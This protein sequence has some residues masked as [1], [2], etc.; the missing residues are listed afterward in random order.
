MNPKVSIVI[1]CFNHG[2]FLPEAIAS[3]RATKREDV[4]I[5]VVDDGSTDVRTRE[6]TNALASQGITLIRKKNGGP[7][8]A[9][10]AGISLARGEYIFPLDGDDR[11]RPDCLHREIPILD[12]NPGV[13]VVY[14]DGEFFGI[15]SGRWGIGPFDAGRLLQWNYIP[16]CALFRRSIW[17]QVGGYDEARILWGLED[18]DFWLN[19]MNHGWKFHYVPEILYEYRVK[20]ESMITRTYGT[21][22]EIAK[23]VA[24]KYGPLHRDAWLRLLKEHESLKEAVAS[25]RQSVAMERESV[26]VTSRNLKRLLKARLRQKLQRGGS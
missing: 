7:A 13:G 2:E 12:S 10:N 4:E 17:E 24:N 8:S 20:T 21:E 23:F 11:I 14:S 5:I 25:E 18:W 22:P 1:P 19:A 26:R 6:E 15:R 9:R 16:C 3:V